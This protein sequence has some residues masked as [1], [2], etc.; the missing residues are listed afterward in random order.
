MQKCVLFIIKTHK[1]NNSQQQQ[2]EYTKINRLTERSF[3]NKAINNRR[4]K[5]RL[6]N[7]G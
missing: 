3:K 1:I 2:K 7:R 5:G 6:N 4:L